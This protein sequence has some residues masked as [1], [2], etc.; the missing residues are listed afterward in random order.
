MTCLLA[1]SILDVDPIVL[2]L[3]IIGVFFLF[4]LLLNVL[5]RE[6]SSEPPKKRL[7]STEP[8]KRAVP[9][10]SPGLTSEQVKQ[11]NQLLNPGASVLRWLQ[12][13]MA[14]AP[15]DPLKTAVAAANEAMQDLLLRV[16]QIKT[17]SFPHQDTLPTGQHTLHGY[18][19]AALATG[20]QPSTGQS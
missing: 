20:D 19:A 11:L 9:N 16:R 17:E 4:H 14:S 13:S 6:R 8:V 18:P 10:N 2:W 12:D 3:G 1:V 15:D 5:I 7:P